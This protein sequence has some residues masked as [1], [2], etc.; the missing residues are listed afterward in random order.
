MV[1]IK[2][3]I[4]KHFFIIGLYSFYLDD[5]KFIE[6]SNSENGYKYLL[7]LLKA[8][9]KDNRYII[10]FGGKHYDMPL[11]QYLVKNDFAEV[12]PRE[13]LYLLCKFE[14]YI[15]NDDAWYK[16]DQY[17]KYKY[18]NY[19]HIDL[20]YFG[21]SNMYEDLSIGNIKRVNSNDIEV[22]KKQLKLD[23]DIIVKLYVKHEDEVMHRRTLAD[24]YGIRPFD[25]SAPQIMEAVMAS[26]FDTKEMYGDSN[27]NSN[28]YAIA[29]DYDY[30]THEI[31]SFKD[32]LLTL[33]NVNINSIDYKFIVNDLLFTIKS[34]ILKVESNYKGYVSDVYINDV[35]SMYPTMLLDYEVVPKHLDKDIF[36]KTYNEIYDL[37]IKTGRKLFKNMLVSMVGYFNSNSSPW[38]KSHDAWAK[39][40]LRSTLYMLQYI[41]KMLVDGTGI[42]F[43]N[44]DSICTI[45]TPIHDSKWT[46][47]YYDTMVIKNINNYIAIGDSVK[48][49]GVFTVN[50]K[51]PVIAKAVANYLKTGESY[52]DYIRDT[53]HPLTD[54]CSVVVTGKE[55]TTMYKSEAIQNVNR[56]YVSNYGDY[57]YKVNGSKIIRAIKEKVVIYN[58]K[59]P[60]APKINY[61]WY[62]SQA[63]KL[64][65]SQTTLF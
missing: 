14:N 16:D 56:C 32:Y 26:K 21:I 24:T 10:S 1:A 33:A 27:P 3:A 23:L 57:L 5:Y 50:N 6:I 60:D 13:L 18:N 7:A 12:K 52:K 61:D 48:T 46:S 35:I 58:T 55:Y 8:I 30:Q 28:I 34:G 37:K 2:T 22:I 65:V 9:A 59:Y 51:Y 40:V 31:N 17:I 42:V 29:L 45:N 20:S 63:E 62:I 43:V 4:T 64:L 47:N 39:I 38:L 36:L 19:M 54:Y 25:I 49:S 11:L 53:N 41:D 15:T 44:L